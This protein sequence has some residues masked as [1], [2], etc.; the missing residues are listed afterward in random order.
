MPTEYYEGI[1]NDVFR[2]YAMTQKNVHNVSIHDNIG[3]H[4]Q[5]NPNFGFFLNYI[6]THTYENIHKD[7]QKGLYQN[8]KSG[9]TEY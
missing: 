9:Y 5:N 2:E 4:E 6:Y 3:L 1:K 7:T 8:A